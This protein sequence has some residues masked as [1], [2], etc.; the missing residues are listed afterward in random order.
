MKRIIN[1]ICLAL[2]AV[3]ASLPF[4]PFYY[5]RSEGMAYDEA[6]GQY[7]PKTFEAAYNTFGNFP[8]L[9]G[10]GFLA[11]IGYIV[12]YSLIGVTAFFFIKDFKSEKKT[13]WF[14]FIPATIVLVIF[15]LMFNVPRGW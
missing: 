12:T 13:K 7:V 3:Y 6:L 1:Y 2:L 8:G 14:L 11:V 5:Y 15:L 10:S 4:I 9:F